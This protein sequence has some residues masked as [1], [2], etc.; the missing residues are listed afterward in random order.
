MMAGGDK[1]GEGDDFDVFCAREH[2]RLVGA[3]GLY[4]G[5]A[6]L[7]EDV[8]QE[9]LVRACLRWST[10]RALEFPAGWVYRVAVN[11]ANSHFRRQAVRR[12]LERRTSASGEHRDPDMPDVVAVREVLAALKPRARTAVVLRYYLDYSVAQTAAAMGIP[13]NTVKTL[14]RRGLAQMNDA[15]GNETEAAEHA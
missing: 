2:A 1:G 6:L 14:V 12:R 9:A 13:Q 3:I 10:V 7:A 11:L 4:C 8:A 15:L 5:D